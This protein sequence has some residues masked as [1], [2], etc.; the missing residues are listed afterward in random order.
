ME[1]AVNNIIA[2]FIL[3]GSYGYGFAQESTPPLERKMSLELNGI[4][5]KETLKLME[6]QGDYL[7][8]YRTNLIEESVQLTRTYTDK[9]TRAILNDLFAGKITYKERG[10]YI[11]LRA[12]G[13]P[14]DKTVQM[15]GY[16]SNK[17]SGETIPYATIY[18]SI[19]LSSTN[20]N[21]YGYYNL[22]LK[23]AENPLFIV[24]KEGYRDTTIQWAQ[25]GTSVYNIRLEALPTVMDSTLDTLDKN[26]KIDWFQRFIPDE[27]Q[28]STFKN[29][30]EEL[31][32]KTQVSFVP[33][34]GTNGNLSSRTTVDYSFNVIGGFNGG[35]RVMEI[36]G[37]FNLD[38]D[39]VSYFQAAGIFNKVGG[40]QRGAQFAGITN[41]NNADV[42]GAQFAGI[43]NITNGEVIGTQSAGI[44]NYVNGFKGAQFAGIGNYSYKSSIGGQF[45][46]IFNKSQGTLRGVQAAGIVNVADHVKGAQIGLLNFS[47]SIEGVPIGFLSFSKKGLHQLEV[48]T[49]ELFHTNLAFKTGVNQ[50]YNTII[51]GIKF[52]GEHPLIGV[53]YG[54]GTSIGV[55]RKSRFFF[56]LQAMHLHRH[57]LTGF[58]PRNVLAKFSV[59]YQWQVSP[60]FAIAAGPSINA[61]GIDTN[62]WSS[63]AYIYN[64]AP[65]NIL[66]SGYA[67]PQV[68][69]GWSVALRF[70]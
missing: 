66:N 60:L 59:T 3:I 8:A 16:V 47:N 24:K 21:E 31:Q 2:L 1:K 68:W 42:H 70:F 20:S 34:I 17:A 25:S 26:A 12:Q 64:D 5:I 46:G 27:E 53:G 6:V 51:G 61:L 15:S 48:S 4:T 54:L 22:T 36:G 19:S 40:H 63:F 11:I 35:A 50:F 14:D 32:R 52:Q 45:A 18:D 55:S 9:T 7:F 44:V 29:F 10:N 38:W 33:N 23:N 62:D 56:D 67:N 43:T 41:I 69:V 49:N 58:N 13:T 57:E 39:S 30:R 37:I 28:K 65:Y